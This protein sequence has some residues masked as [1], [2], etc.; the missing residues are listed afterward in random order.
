M[1][2]KNIYVNILMCCVLYCIISCSG[3]DDI[4]AIDQL[5]PDYELPQGKSDADNRI[6]EYYNQ[7]GSFILYEYTQ[8]DFIYGGA[9]AFEYELPDPQ[10]VGDMLDLLEDI[11][12]D[13]YPAEFHQKYMPYRIFLAKYIQQVMGSSV[14]PL[15]TVAGTNC[16]YVG[17]CSDTLQKITP[18]TKLSFKND[19]QAK[20]WNQWIL[21]MELPEDFFNVSD[22]TTAVDAYT[23]ESPNY[24]RT[25]GFV[26]DYTYGVCK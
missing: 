15:F 11:W 19:I 17:Y 12:F 23:P 21:D 9:S 4:G 25:R 7:Y 24:A 20:L 14:Y 5:T 13:F 22:Y 2:M 10:Y 16:Q 8:L 6:V 1:I 3:N 18:A 26:A